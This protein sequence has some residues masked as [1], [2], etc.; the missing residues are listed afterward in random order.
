MV[1]IDSVTA[2]FTVYRLF[3]F[4]LYHLAS[5][6]VLFCE[7]PCLVLGIKCDELVLLL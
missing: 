3:A 7:I 1:L 2:S 6:E 4:T 5:E